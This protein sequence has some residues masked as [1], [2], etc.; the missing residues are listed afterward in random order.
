MAYVRPH[1]YYFPICSSWGFEGRGR[2]STSQCL[3]AGKQV[4]FTV[5]DME[6]FQ[7]KEG[8]AR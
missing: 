3:G 6:E 7:E 5:S 4:F 2:E 1:I 8:M